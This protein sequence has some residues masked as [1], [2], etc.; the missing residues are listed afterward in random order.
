MRSQRGRAGDPTIPR[1][2]R[3]TRQRKDTAVNQK[4]GQTAPP[5]GAQ[6]RHQQNR[7]R[8]S[9]RQGKG[10]R[11]RGDEADRGS[12][13]PAWAGP[14]ADGFDLRILWVGV[15]RTK[16]ASYTFL[17]RKIERPL[18]TE[19][20]DAFAAALRATLKRERPGPMTDPTTELRDGRPDAEADAEVTAPAGGGSRRRGRPKKAAGEVRSARVQVLFTAAE[21][22]QL[23]GL[24][25]EAGLSVSEYLRRRGLDRPVES[26]LDAADRGRVG[27][28]GANLNQLARAANRAG[29]VERGA[30]VDAAV[31]EVRELVRVL[32]ARALG[33]RPEEPGP[34]PAGGAP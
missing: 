11:T 31:A 28:L 10:R 15:W 1:A 21:K 34:T 29:Q 12:P 5:E 16:R 20:S 22:V 13:A 7:N 33:V 18:A 30:A 3:P 27:R 6:D 17:C 2:R 32:R 23:E 4:W 19:R 9:R 8:R 26:V 24:A 25:S 14:L